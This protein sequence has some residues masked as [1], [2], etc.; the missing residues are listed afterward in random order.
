MWTSPT[1]KLGRIHNQ[2]LV[3]ESADERQKTTHV[4]HT[5]SRP[6]DCLLPLQPCNQFLPAVR[7]GPSKSVPEVHA[8]PDECPQQ[9]S[10]PHLTSRLPPHNHLTSRTIINFTQTTAPTRPCSGW[11][12]FGSLHQL[13]HQKG[14]VF[15]PKWV[16]KHQPSPHHILEPGHHPPRHGRI[17]TAFQT[18]PGQPSFQVT[19][20]AFQWVALK[21]GISKFMSVHLIRSVVN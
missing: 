15:P 21:L 20:D 9:T 5:L 2:S 7:F 11:R 1:V 10:R 4:L 14:S 12:G 3:P 19:L 16:D 17:Q 13:L 6:I 18:L 8:L